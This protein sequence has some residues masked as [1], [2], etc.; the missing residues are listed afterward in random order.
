VVVEGRGMIGQ[1]AWRGE[2]AAVRGMMSGRCLGGLLAV[3]RRGY[4]GSHWLGAF[5]LAPFTESS[6]PRALIS[7]RS[8]SVLRGDVFFDEAFAVAFV[9]QAGPGPR[10]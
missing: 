3:R 5:R 7:L 2:M 8:K 6:Q 1:D 9:R 10:I 4:D